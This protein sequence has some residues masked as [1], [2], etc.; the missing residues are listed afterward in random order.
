MEKFKEYLNNV[1][2]VYDEYKTLCEG[3]VNPWWFLPLVKVLILAVI[4]F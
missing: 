4:L 3:I 1:G 2:A